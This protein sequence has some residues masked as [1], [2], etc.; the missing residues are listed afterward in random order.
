MLL[1]EA[2]VKESDG[3]RKDQIYPPSYGDP[4]YVF[5]WVAIL[6]HLIV[7]WINESSLTV[8]LKKISQFKLKS[9]YA[10]S[11]R[12]VVSAFVKRRTW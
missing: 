2:F 3:I 4:W 10:V 1:T 5:Y 8:L 11:I 7:T 9:I 12:D 6:N